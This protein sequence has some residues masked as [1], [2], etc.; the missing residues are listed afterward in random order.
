MRFLK[1]YLPPNTILEAYTL[2]GTKKLIIEVLGVLGTNIN[3]LACTHDDSEE[4][5]RKVTKLL[6]AR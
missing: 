1:L 3:F 4:E 5:K 2:Q 6:E